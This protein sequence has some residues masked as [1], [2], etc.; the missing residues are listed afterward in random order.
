M[1]YII[2]EMYPQ[3]YPLLAKFLYESI[4]QREGEVTASQDYN[5]PA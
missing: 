1:E 3:E 5:Q 2:R 4:F